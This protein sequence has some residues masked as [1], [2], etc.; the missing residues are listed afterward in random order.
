MY[1]RDRHRRVRVWTDDEGNRPRELTGDFRILPWMLGYP[2]P[3][4]QESS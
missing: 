3:A 2:V 1:T 4:W